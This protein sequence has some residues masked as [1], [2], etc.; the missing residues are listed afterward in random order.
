MQKSVMELGAPVLERIER[1]VSCVVM[2]DREMVK[3][4]VEGGSGVW[5]QVMSMQERKD[6]QKGAR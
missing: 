6:N 4:R 3:G 2:R 1:E 5:T